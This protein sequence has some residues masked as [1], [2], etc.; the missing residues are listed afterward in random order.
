M[1][2]QKDIEVEVIPTE[3]F[4]DKLISKKDLNKLSTDIDN[5]YL[6]ND[7]NLVQFYLPRIDV[8]S[9]KFMRDLSNGEKKNYKEI[10]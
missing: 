1:I 9:V 2:L 7:L 8:W 6:N 4:I 5:T 3:E 10:F